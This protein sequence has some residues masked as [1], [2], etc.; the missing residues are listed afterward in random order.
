[1]PTTLPTRAT[2]APSGL[3]DVSAL[4]ESIIAEVQASLLAAVRDALSQ[5]KINLPPPNV[6]VAAPDVTVTPTFEV[7]GPG[8][9]PAPEVH[10]DIPALDLSALIQR[11]SAIE[12]LL[13]TPVTKTV[14]RDANGLIKSVKE[15]RG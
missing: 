8:V 6:T 4:R 5:V 12:T 1:M 10:V 11:L 7:A 15:T 2:A 9:L 13:R 3:V 14:E